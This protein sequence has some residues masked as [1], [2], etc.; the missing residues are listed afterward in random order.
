MDFNHLVWVQHPVGEGWEVV[1]D[2]VIWVAVGSLDALWRNTPE[3]VGLDGRGSDQAGK[4]EAVGDFLR[5]GIGTRQIFV[6][7]VS[8]IDG[9]VTFTDGRHRFAWL[10]DHGLRAMPIEV[11]EESLEVFK[12]HVETTERIGRFDPVAR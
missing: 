7:T 11:P 6:P 4:Y 2:P 12:T 1:P 5:F 3:Y 8:M 10:R 9:K